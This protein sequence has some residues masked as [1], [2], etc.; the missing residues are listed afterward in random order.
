MDV[1]A[2]FKTLAGVEVA[3]VEEDGT[4]ITLPKGSYLM[5]TDYMNGD[6]GGLL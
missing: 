5:I 1:R 3:R 6:D 2:V 4:D